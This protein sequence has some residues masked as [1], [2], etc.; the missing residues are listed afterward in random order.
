MNCAGAM[1]CQRWDMGKE[2]ASLGEF[3]TVSYA[4][5]TA[6]EGVVVRADQGTVAN[7]IARS[8]VLNVKCAKKSEPYPR[9]VSEATGVSFL[10]FFCFA[11]SFSLL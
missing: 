7:G 8:M 1:A 3:S 5:A 10:I 4:D 11:Y 6:F 9:F 2:T